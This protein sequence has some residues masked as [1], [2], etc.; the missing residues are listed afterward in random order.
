MTTFP[1]GRGKRLPAVTSP[2]PSWAGPARDTWPRTPMWPQS[3]HDLVWR[4]ASPHPKVKRGSARGRSF[5]RSRNHAPGLRM[6]AES[7]G[8]V[9]AR[10]AA[11]TH[12]GTARSGV[13]RGQV[14]RQSHAEPGGS[15][16]SAT[17]QWASPEAQRK[18]GLGVCPP[19]GIGD[20]G[21]RSDAVAAAPPS[22]SR[23]GSRREP[24]TAARS[25]G[26]TLRISP[27]STGSITPVM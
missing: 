26:Q 3:N 2:S 5:M 20:L 24:L 19:M 12:S 23:P 21:Q 9:H 15:L 8:E 13:Q 22:R 25:S 7:L 10:R 6:G 1:P 11:R 16:L 4:R 14:Q 27:P 18:R 17:T